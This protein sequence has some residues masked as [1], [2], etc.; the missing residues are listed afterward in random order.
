MC[1]S[2]SSD[3]KDKYRI[4]VPPV[5]IRIEKGKGNKVRKL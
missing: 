5:E 1:V 3:G 2:E 4:G